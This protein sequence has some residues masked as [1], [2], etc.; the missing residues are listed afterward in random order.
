ML[1]VYKC[2]VKSAKKHFTLIELLVVIA[3]IAILAGI[4]L[5][6]LNRA[7][8]KAISI[9]CVNNMKQISIYALSYRMDNGMLP[10][11]ASAKPWPYL[12]AENS[13]I[14]LSGFTCPGRTS[15]ANAWVWK[16]GKTYS[17]LSADNFK[18][19]DYGMN[20]VA[21]SA[22]ENRVKRPS[23]KA[24][25]GES[26]KIDY[27]NNPASGYHG[28]FEVYGYL[29]GR[30]TGTN[31]GY[32]W[33]VHETNSNMLWYDGHVST[34]KSAP[35]KAGAQALHY[36]LLYQNHLMEKWSDWNNVY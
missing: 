23:D 3:I 27:V 35:G 19:C 34:L 17:Q 8:A 4:L 1:K 28:W 18:F 29:F 22:R 11:I 21:R 7:K 15:R 16:T 32:F 26:I 30:A 25:I 31:M 33:P 12:L 36:N 13:K 20:N 10:L 6:A 9:A 5:P 2:K 24:W 14:N